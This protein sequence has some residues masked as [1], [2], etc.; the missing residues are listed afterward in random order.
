LNVTSP[1]KIEQMEDED[2]SMVNDT[3]RPEEA[4]ATGV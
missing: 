1:S 2:A 4:V 3:G